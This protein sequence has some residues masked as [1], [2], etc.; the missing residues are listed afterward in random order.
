[1]QRYQSL[2]VTRWFARA[3]ATKAISKGYRNICAALDDLQNDSTQQ[4]ATRAKAVRL[5]HKMSQLETALMAIIWNRI[6]ERFQATSESLQRYN[7][8]IGI[9][10]NLYESLADFLESIRSDEEFSKMEDEAKQV[11]D[12]HEYK[13]VGSRRRKCAKLFH[14]DPSYN[15]IFES[16][17]PSEKFKVQTYYA[18]LDMLVNELKKGEHH[19]VPFIRS[20]RCS[21]DLQTCQV[22][23]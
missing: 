7:V 19:T 20:L 16:Q 14:D 15:D 22:L 4:P 12:C 17:S 11:F 10:V 9:V 23:K 21:Y 5:L 3:D 8:E 2:S 1:M 13:E 6:L 18:I